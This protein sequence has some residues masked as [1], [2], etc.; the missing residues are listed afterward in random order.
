PEV[1]HEERLLA[2]TELA[3][4]EVAPVLERDRVRLAFDL[5]EETQLGQ[6]RPRQEQGDLVGWR[7]LRLGL[8][9][10][11]RVLEE[12]ALDSKGEAGDQRL[13]RAVLPDAGRDPTWL[14]GTRDLEAHHVE[15]LAEPVQSRRAGVAGVALTAGLAPQGRP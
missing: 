11:H 2:E 9:R 15:L 4:G 12:P 7:E 13:A 10:R 1:E 8:S 6:K 3:S 5:D 14:G